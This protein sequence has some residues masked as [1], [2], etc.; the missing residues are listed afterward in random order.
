[1]KGVRKM[2]GILAENKVRIAVDRVGGPTKASALLGVSNWTVHSWM[3]TGRI[4]NID[5]AK[6][7]AKESGMAVTALRPTR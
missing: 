7:L 5:H 6:A 4:S 1:M 2:I 3:K